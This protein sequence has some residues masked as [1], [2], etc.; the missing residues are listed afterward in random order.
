MRIEFKQTAPK[1]GCFGD[2]TAHY[3]VTLDGEYTVQEF[4]NEVITNRSGEWGR[5]G[6]AKGDEYHAIFSNTKCEYRWGKLLSRLSDEYLTRKIKRVTAHGGY[7]NMDYL[8][9]LK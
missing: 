8:L 2:C 3:D 1:E 6:I 5:I 4:I 7:T 9:R